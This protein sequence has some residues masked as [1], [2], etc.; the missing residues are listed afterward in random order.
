MDFEDPL[1]L[2]SYFFS[3]CTPVETDRGEYSCTEVIIFVKLLK[4]LRRRKA[5]SAAAKKTNHNFDGLDET[6]FW[7]SAVAVAAKCWKSP[8]TQHNTQDGDKKRQD[9]TRPEE[10]EFREL[11]AVRWE[12][13]ASSFELRAPRWKMPSSEHSGSYNCCCSC[14]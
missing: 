10:S 6:F 9:K 13:R 8:P 12:M 14:C 7:L 1:P 2:A 5:G 11:R 4:C 3:L